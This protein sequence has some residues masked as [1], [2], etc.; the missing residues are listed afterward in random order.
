MI[1]LHLAKNYDRIVGSTI[2]TGEERALLLYVY[3]YKEYVLV[4]EASTAPTE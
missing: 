3:S 1:H 2:N 4:T